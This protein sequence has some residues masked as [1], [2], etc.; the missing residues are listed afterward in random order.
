MPRTAPRP[1]GNTQIIATARIAMGLTQQQLADALHV[2]IRTVRR[3]ERE[4][5][6][7]ETRTAIELSSVL[8]ISLFDITH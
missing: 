1:R 7:P 6:V 5:A 8:G 4:D 2:S 3:W